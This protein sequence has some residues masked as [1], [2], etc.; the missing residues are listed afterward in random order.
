MVRAGKSSDDLERTPLVYIFLD[1]PLLRMHLLL[2]FETV[3]S[4][5]KSWDVVRRAK[6]IDY[7]KETQLSTWSDVYQL[8]YSTK[9]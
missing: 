9:F 8:W 1:T 4:D 2:P 7:V 6:S 3:Q 5:L